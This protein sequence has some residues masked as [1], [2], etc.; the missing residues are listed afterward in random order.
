MDWK[1]SPDL[2]ALRRGLEQE[3]LNEVVGKVGVKMEADVE[4]NERKLG[5]RRVNVMTALV[6]LPLL[7]IA[8]VVF[9]SSS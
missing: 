5:T 4:H 3:E 1:R 6:A 2:A 7:A 9:A 8:C